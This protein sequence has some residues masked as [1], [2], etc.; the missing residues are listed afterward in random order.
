LLAA[1]TSAYCVK[2]PLQKVAQLSVD[3]MQVNGKLGLANPE[4]RFLKRLFFE[5]VPDREGKTESTR[6]NGI[7]PNRGRSGF[8][9]ILLGRG[10]HVQVWDV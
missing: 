9:H 10:R 8:E 6:A 7:D 1:L 4:W 2:S 5:H 3:W